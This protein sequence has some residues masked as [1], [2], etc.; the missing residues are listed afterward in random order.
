MP[1]RKPEDMAPNYY[2]V[3]AF[4]PETQDYVSREDADLM[5]LPFEEG[6][7]SWAVFFK[8]VDKKPICWSSTY[9]DAEQVCRALN[10]PIL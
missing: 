3:K 8:P 10:Y 7:D 6:W 9:E 4:S 1:F 5:R 2:H